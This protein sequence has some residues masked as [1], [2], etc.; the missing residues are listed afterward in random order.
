M[1]KSIF[2]FK[3][4]CDLYCP[5]CSIEL[6]DFYINKSG[7]ENKELALVYFLNSLQF[8]DSTF[9]SCLLAL[10]LKN[11][12]REVLKKLLIRSIKQGNNYS[13]YLFSAIIFN[14]DKSKGLKMLLELS[15]K[16]KEP[17]I[18]LLNHGYKNKITIQNDNLISLKSYYLSIYPFPELFKNTESK[19]LMLK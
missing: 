12:S 3:Q 9:L 17:S 8:I 7:L 1:K 13:Y 6:G 18:F 2:L 10:S 16:Y 15:N 4:E 14:E 11:T 5:Y 19:V